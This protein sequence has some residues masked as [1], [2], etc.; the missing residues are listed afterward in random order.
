MEA[1]QKLKVICQ[2][3]GTGGLPTSCYSMGKRTGVEPTEFED[4][5]PYSIKAMEDLLDIDE[6]IYT[7]NTV[8][9]PPQQNRIIKGQTSLVLTEPLKKGDPPLPHGLHL[10]SSHTMYNSGS[11]KIHVSLYNTKDQ[12]MI[13]Q[14]GTP[15]G[16]MVATNVVPNKKLLPGTLEALNK[17]EINE[18][19][20]LF[21]EER[22]RKLFER[23]DLLGLESWMPGNKER[24]LDLLLEFHDVFALEEGEM[25]CTEATKHHTE[26][27]D[28][29][30]FKE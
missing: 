25:G 15:V 27:T 13:I 20:S 12:L 3:P 28:P 11:Q 26:V 9:I 24:A 18:V 16:H 22:R 8:V 29:H 2:A 7:V 23:L 14:K 21:L 10:Q 1:N 6:V 19:Q 30:P 17:I 5:T 4:H